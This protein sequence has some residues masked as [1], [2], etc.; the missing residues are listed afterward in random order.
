MVERLRFGGDIDDEWMKRPEIVG[1]KGL[2]RGKA[3]G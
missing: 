2:V 3:R 1:K